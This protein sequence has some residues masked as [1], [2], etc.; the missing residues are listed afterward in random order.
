MIG[1]RYFTDDSLLLQSLIQP[2]RMPIATEG[3]L[4]SICLVGAFLGNLFFGMM[5][6][7]FGRKTMFEYAL[8]V[9]IFASFFSVSAYFVCVNVA[10]VAYLMDHAISQSVTQPISQ[11]AT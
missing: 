8:L 6:D 2:G 3:I 4:L 7:I 5:A 10:L 1:R 9:M 11:L